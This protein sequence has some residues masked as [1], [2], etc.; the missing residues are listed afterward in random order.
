MILDYLKQAITKE[1]LDITA[2]PV[3]LL[4]PTSSS[5]TG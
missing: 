2:A 3:A 1:G 5:V 4:A